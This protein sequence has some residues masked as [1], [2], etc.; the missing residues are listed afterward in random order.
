MA[1]GSPRMA[2]LFDGMVE[3]KSV[4]CQPQARMGSRS[5]YLALT[6]QESA[7]YIFIYLLKE[8]G[9]WKTRLSRLLCPCCGEAGKQTQGK[10][11]IL[12]GWGSGK[13]ILSTSGP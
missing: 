11:N 7:Q 8:T 5:Q 1:W 3:T 13:H 4:V 2:I 6:G 10:I 12:Y 9:R